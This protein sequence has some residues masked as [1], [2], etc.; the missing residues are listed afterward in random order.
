MGSSA[1]GID[2]YKDTFY[3]PQIVAARLSGGVA[4]VTPNVTIDDDAKFPPPQITIRSLGDGT[5]LTAAQAQLSAV[6]ED[7]KQPLK[8]IKVLVN[9]RLVGG[10][11]LSPLTG[12]RGITVRTEK[13]EVPANQRRVEFSLP[14]TLEPGSNRIRITASNGYSNSTET[15]EISYQTNTA[16]LPN[17]WILAVGI[18]KYDSP[19]LNNLNYA[20]NDAREIVN[21]FKAQEGKRFGK[22][23]SLLITDDTPVKPTV[24]NI[25]DNFD[26]LSKA[27]Q[28]DVILLFLAGHGV[29]DSRGSFS[30]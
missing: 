10:D 4:V 17:L 6:V 9:G 16:W 5:R 1:Y 21:I 11:E 24:A 2:Q 28:Y 13:I 19:V 18:N 26:F 12:T 8:E 7:Q 29:N 15:V 25:I 27:S 3:R 22:V 23:N 20:V 30:L 14:V